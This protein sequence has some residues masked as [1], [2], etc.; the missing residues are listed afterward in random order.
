MK[1]IQKKTLQYRRRQRRVRAKVRGT[2]TRPRLTIFRS[3]KHISVQL[4]DDEARRTIIAASDRDVASHAKSTKK[5]SGKT[6]KTAALVGALIAERSR[7]KNISHA[8]FDRGGYRYHGAV[9]SV[10]EAARKGGLNL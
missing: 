6:A 1:H 2:D 7:E 9:A 4:I 5:Q 3:L 8:V 10:A